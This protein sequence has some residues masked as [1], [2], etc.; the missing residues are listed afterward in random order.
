MSDTIHPPTHLNP[1]MISMLNALAAS[2]LHTHRHIAV[3]LQQKL[4]YASEPVDKL[5][6]VSACWKPGA[7]RLMKGGGWMGG[8]LISQSCV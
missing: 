3:G 8:W 6:K 7:V 2:S 4:F 1:Q 5:H